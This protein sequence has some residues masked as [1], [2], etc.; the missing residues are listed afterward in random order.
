[1]SGFF[2]TGTFSA[3]TLQGSGWMHFIRLALSHQRL[4]FIRA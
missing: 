3:R 1:V 4:T 2:Y